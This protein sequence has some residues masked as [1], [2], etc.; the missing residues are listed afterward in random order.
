MTDL[1][2]DIFRLPAKDISEDV[3]WWLEL[4]VFE[5]VRNALVHG[6]HK[7]PS[8][9]VRI[10]Y[11]WSEDHFTITVTD[12]GD[13][14]DLSAVD[15]PTSGKNIAREKGRGVFLMKHVMDSVKYNATDNSITMTKRF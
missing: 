6:N 3:V 9:K 4:A 1:C 5:C 14:F 2:R 10:E 15:D 13:G 12:E 7:D 8:K 11:E